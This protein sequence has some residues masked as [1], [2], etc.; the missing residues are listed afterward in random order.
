MPGKREAPSSRGQS[1]RR[2]ASSRSQ[3]DVYSE[4]PRRNTRARSSYDDYEYE[5]EGATRRYD[6]RRSSDRRRDYEREY[7]GGQDPRSADRQRSRSGRDGDPRRRTSGALGSGSNRPRKKKKKRI[8]RWQKIV[9]TI[10]AVLIALLLAAISLVYGKLNRINRIQQVERISSSEQTFDQDTDE[11][12][13]ITD[14]TVDFGTAKVLE[15]QNVINILLVGRDARDLSERGRS[16]SMIVLSM[17]RNTQ[18]ISL[19][20]LMRDSYVQ[21]PGYKNNKMNSAFSY[22]G[23][24]LLDETIS[25]NFGITI[26]YNVGVNFSGFEQV[27]DQL[28]GIDISLTEDEALY[29]MADEETQAEGLFE[30]VNHLDGKEALC[31]ARARYV[32]TGKEANDFGRTYRQRMVMTTVYKEMMKKSLPEIWTILD[33]IMDCMETDMTNTEMISIGTEFYNMNI[34]TMQAYRIPCDGEY[35]DQTINKMSVLV[36]DFDA[37]RQ[38]LQDWLYSDTPVEDHSIETAN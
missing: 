20:S 10:L 6:T 37:A 28:G 8:P 22:G 7:D 32:G 23:Y 24:E 4:Q 34:S 33:S 3:Q 14:E 13:T 35:T 27:V 16:D 18:Q 25:Q 29:L 30:G 9:I 2:P 17:N 11:A 36:L 21:I 31:Y 19:V 1:S 15:D 5:N 38:N 12:D 26:D